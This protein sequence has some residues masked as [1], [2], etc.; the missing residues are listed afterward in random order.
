[1]NYTKETSILFVFIKDLSLLNLITAVI[2]YFSVRFTC[3]YSSIIWV[4]VHNSITKLVD[5]AIDNVSI[6]MRRKKDLQKDYYIDRIFTGI[7]KKLLK[8]T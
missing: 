6:I 2:L 7:S 1:M 5:S 8:T 3:F 4:V